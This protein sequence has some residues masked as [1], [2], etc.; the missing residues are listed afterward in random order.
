M[1]KRK[2][3]LCVL[4]FH[5]WTEDNKVARIVMG[6]ETAYG[7]GCLRCGQLIEKGRVRP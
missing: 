6:S 4:G 1:S 7:R 5:N 2:P 3:L